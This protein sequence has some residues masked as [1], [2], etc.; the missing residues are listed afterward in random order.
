MG[1]AI[2]RLQTLRVADVMNRDVVTVGAHQR[3]S[4]V[5][6]IFRQHGISCAPVVDEMDRCV[7][8]VSATDFLKRDAEGEPS[9]PLGGEEHQVVHEGQSGWHI[10][11]GAPDRACAFM[12]SA[13][14]T[15]APDAPLL[16]AA[17]IM[18]TDHIHRLP[19]LGSAGRVEGMIS[20]MD[21]AAVVVNVVHELDASLLDR[22]T[23]D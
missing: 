10:E 11:D 4:E 22:L 21:I 8:I 20:T 19:V 15:V 3:M 23:S 13:V 1:R 9:L 2:N 14:Q 17:M 6:N 7:G 16:R 5:A 18:S 12:T